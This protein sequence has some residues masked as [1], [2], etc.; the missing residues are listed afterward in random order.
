MASQESKDLQAKKK[1]EAQIPAEQTRPGLVFT[2]A[3]DIY[4]TEKEIV[5]LADMPGVRTDDVTIDLK[6][7]TLTLSGDPQ[8]QETKDETDILREYRTGKYYRQFTLS[9]IIDQE[10]IEAKL[11]DGVLNLVLPKVE[12][13]TP[14]KI[15]VQTA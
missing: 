15:E 3:V 10:K 11:H 6:D 12:K 1:E 9:E 2:P 8:T 13:A 5:V 4:E 14:R 7:N